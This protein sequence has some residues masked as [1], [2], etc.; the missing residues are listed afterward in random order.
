ME[1][2]HPDRVLCDMERGTPLGVIDSLSAG[3]RFVTRH[4]E[5]LVWPLFLDMVLWFLP[6]LSIEPLTRQM[7]SLYARMDAAP[8]MDDTLVQMAAQA[9]EMLAVLGRTVNLASL[10][11]NASLYHVP[12]LVAS[13]PELKQGHPTVEIRSLSTAGLAAI[14]FMVAGLFLGVV[15]MNLLAHALPLG[16][17][18]KPL[19]P[20]GLLAT[21]WR[22]W[23]RTLRLVVAIAMALLVAYI[24]VLIGVSILGLISPV[25]A[26]GALMVASGLVMVA[27]IYLYFVT[28]GLVLDDLRVREAVTRSVLLVSRYFWATLAFIVLSFVITE[29]I[30]VLLVQ[31]ATTGVAGTV[32]AA[33]VNAF[34]GTGLAMALLVF[35]RTRILRLK[36]E[37][38]PSAG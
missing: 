12:S 37:L 18:Q 34:I 28:A 16:Q 25:L 31:V 3:Y 21:A 10:L 23:L 38:S 32:V 5:L 30:G 33:L 1:A 14:G 13:I 22:Q 7:A 6:R 15:Y 11:I 2:K 35:Y 8:G 20:R 19:S 9:E 26:S 36:E 4:L 29:G 24:P 27:F 17:G